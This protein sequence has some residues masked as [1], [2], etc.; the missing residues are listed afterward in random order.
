MKTTIYILSVLLLL[1]TKS[2]AQ[3]GGFAGLTAATDLRIVPQAYSP[4]LIDPGLTMRSG[5]ENIT[6]IHRGIALSEDALLGIHWFSESNMAG[7]IG[8]ISGRTAKYLLLDLPLDYFS[9]VLGHEYYGH[10]ARYRELNIDGIHYGFSM[11]P[12]YGLGGGEASIDGALPISLHEDLVIWAGGLEVQSLIGRNLSMRWM[13]TDEIN[14]R[15]ASLYFWSWQI[16][17]TYIQDTEED[18]FDGTRDND[19][20][21]YTRIIN[22]GAV[23]TDP[24]TIIMTV[25]DLKSK[26]KI[27]V[28][29]PFLYYSLFSI[30]KVYMWDGNSSGGISTLKLGGIDYLPSLRAG[31][32]PFGIE[33]HLENYLRHRN[34][35]SLIDFRIGDQTF[36]DSWGGLGVF[37]QNIYEP[38]PFSFDM[39]VDIWNQPEIQLRSNPTAHR[40]GGMGGAFSV[41]GHYNLS[42]SKHPLSAALEIGYKSIGFLEGYNLDASPILLIGLALALR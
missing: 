30:L 20:R 32:T 17:F 10:G 33:Y 9:I 42:D 5:V 36:H 28:A 40:G 12:P 13:L 1:S 31:L 37:I 29:N 34:T 11:P 14:Y 3:N 16:M 26:T 27:N 24:D 6:T 22:A 15:E 4:L 21:A 23:Y 8:G 19:L 25:K 41:R 35:V 7:K 2:G 38:K 39:H 18:L